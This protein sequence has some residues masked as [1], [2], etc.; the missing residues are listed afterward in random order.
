MPDHSHYGPFIKDWPEIWNGYAASRTDKMW[1]GDKKPSEVIPPMVKDI[2]KKFF[3][4][5]DSAPKPAK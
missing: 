5:D 4:I 2:N 1:F 3:G